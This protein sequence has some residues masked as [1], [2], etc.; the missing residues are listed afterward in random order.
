MSGIVDLPWKFQ[1]SFISTLGTRGPYR[2][3]VSGVDINSDGTDTAFLPGWTDFD[4]NPTKERLSQAVTAWN[5]AYPDLPTASARARP[6]A[7]ASPSWCCRPTTPSAA[8]T[9]RH[10]TFA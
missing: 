10:R 3:S 1:V 8:N 6:A 5:A 4:R 7:R 9:V 2:P